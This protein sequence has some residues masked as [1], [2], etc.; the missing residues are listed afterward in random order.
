MLL[1]NLTKFNMAPKNMLVFGYVFVTNLNGDQQEEQIVITSN[2]L[3]FLAPKL[4]ITSP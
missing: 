1:R 3:Y 4:K 2:C